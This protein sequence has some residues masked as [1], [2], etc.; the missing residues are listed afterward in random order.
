[1]AKYKGKGTKLQ[2]ST[3]SGTTFVDVAQI[4]D[5]SPP[6]ESGNSIDVT[7]H[8]S[9]GNHSEFVAGLRDGGEVALSI[10]FDPEDTASH[11]KLKELFDSGEVLPWRVVFPSANSAHMQFDGFVNSFSGETPQDDKITADCSLKVTGKPVLTPN[12]S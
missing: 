6:S 2:Y 7:T 5:V 12:P 8:D 10:A 9:P 11:A 4:L 1:M 3:D